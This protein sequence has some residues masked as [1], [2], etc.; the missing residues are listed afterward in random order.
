MLEPTNLQLVAFQLAVS[1][2]I[3]VG[4]NWLG[5]QS[6][7]F[8]YETLT[9]FT[10]REDAVAFNFLFR[11]ITPVVL[12]ILVAASCYALGLDAFTKD[13]HHAVAYYIAFRV[14]LNG[15]RGRWLLLP[16]RRLL[17]QWVVT[18]FLAHLAYSHLIV[19]KEYL[20][21]DLKTV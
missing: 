7:M 11:A 1:L 4:L 15:L 8:G 5:R 20:L 3:F 10:E 6:D 2:S 19:R 21:P 18:L 9:L 17:F 16:W 13:L 12:L 14:G